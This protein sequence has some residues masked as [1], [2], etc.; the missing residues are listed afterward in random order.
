MKNQNE[1]ENQTGYMSMGMCLGMSIGV[2]IGASTDN[3][4]LWLPLGIS[5]GISIGAM[6][7]AKNC[8]KGA[9]TQQEDTKELALKA[10]ESKL[11][12]REYLS[13]KKYPAEL[14]DILDTSDV[15]KFKAAVDKI[16]S[17][18]GVDDK[19]AR[20]A[21]PP[22][23]AAPSNGGGTSAANDPIRNAFMP[24]T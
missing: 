20:F 9:D 1:S 6:I 15:E 3:L 23:F 19:R 8:K 22:R 18:Y 24:K 7:D 13:E 21:N 12:C 14:L 16:Q 4:G 11:D 10:R 17:V 5:I 2:A